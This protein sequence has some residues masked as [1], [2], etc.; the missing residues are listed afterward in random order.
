[1][2]TSAIGNRTRVL[3]IWKA[4]HAKRTITLDTSLNTVDEILELFALLN[5]EQQNT[6]LSVIGQL[7]A[8]E[9]TTYKIENDTT[10]LLGQFRE[11]ERQKLVLRA[12]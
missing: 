9:E 2:Y 12:S 5:D 8:Y 4:M 11:L 6:I 1:M 3:L 10:L 7:L